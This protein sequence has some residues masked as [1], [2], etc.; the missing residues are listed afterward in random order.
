MQRSDED[1]SFINETSTSY[2]TDTDTLILCENSTGIDCSQDKPVAHSTPQQSNSI[3]LE[4]DE[5]DVAEAITLSEENNWWITVGLQKYAAKWSIID[6]LEFEA[7]LYRALQS[8]Y[9]G[10]E[11]ELYRIGA[12]IPR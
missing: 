10:F 11:F 8:A 9:T 6:Q 2:S 1:G 12:R 3:V 4:L 5:G 7:E